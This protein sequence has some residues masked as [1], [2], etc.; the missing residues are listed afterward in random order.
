LCLVRSRAADS[1]AP[2][3]GLE[4]VAEWAVDAGRDGPLV[5]GGQCSGFFSTGTYG[6]MTSYNDISKGDFTLSGRVFL[7]LQDVKSEDF[8]QRN[9]FG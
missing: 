8:A 2:L 9:H 1:C 7:E 5:M 6:S 4:A 3:S